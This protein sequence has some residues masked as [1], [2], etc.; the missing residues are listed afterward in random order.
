MLR[1]TTPED[2]A[3]LSD[4]A[5]GKWGSKGASLFQKITPVIF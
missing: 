2:A 3:L 5:R 4:A 1:G